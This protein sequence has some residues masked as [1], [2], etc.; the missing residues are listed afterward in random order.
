[1]DEIG[2]VTRNYYDGLGRLEVVVKNLITTTYPLTGTEPPARGSDPTTNLR[3]DY[4][5]DLAGN[6]TQ[7]VDPLGVVTRYDFDDLNRLV[8]VLENFQGSAAPDEE[9][10]VTT[11]YTYDVKGNLVQI[12]DG[13][14]HPTTRVYDD[15][16]RLR[17]EHDALNHTW[18]YAY[19]PAGNRVQV[20]D[21]LPITGTLG[22]TYDALGNRLTLRYPDEKTVRYLY[23]GLNRLVRVTD[24]DTQIT[25]YSYDAAS[26]QTV[27]ELPNGVT[28]DYMYDDLGRVL[29]MTHSTLTETL[30][31]FGYTYDAMG[32][33]VQAVESVQMPETPT[34]TPTLT[35][36]LTATPTGTSTATPTA[37]A[38]LTPTL[39]P[40][41]TST[42][43]PF[44]TVTPTLTATLT[45]TPTLTATLEATPTLSPTLTATLTSTPT[46]TP[47]HTS[48]PTVTPTPTGG[49]PTEP[50]T[51]TPSPTPTATSTHTP[52]LTPTRTSTP[53]ATP[54]DLIF[55]DS[56]ESGSF[57]AWSSYTSSGDLTVTGNAALVGNYG[58]LN[59]VNHNGTL[60]VQD[61][62]PNNESS[63]RARF[64]FDPNTIQMNSAG[65]TVFQAYDE[66]TMQPIKPVVRIE[67]G[68]V[69]TMNPLFQV[70]VAIRKDNNEWISSSAYTFSDG[71][72]AFE[73]RWKAATGTGANNGILELWLDGVLKYS[74]TAVDNDTHR[75]DLARLGVVS[76]PDV[77]TSGSHCL[78]YFESRQ[79]TYIGLVTGAVGCSGG[80]LV[81]D[82]LTPDTETP[83]TET[84]DTLLFADGFESGD[85]SAW[86]SYTNDPD[87]TVAT[88]A[89]LSG[90][91]GLAVL[92]DDYR[93]VLVR[94]D[95]PNA[96]TSYQVRFYLDPHSLW[97]NGGN[98]TI[99][100]GGMT[101]NMSVLTLDLGHQPDMS[102]YQLFVSTRLEDHDWLFSPAFTISDGPH[103]IEIGW[104]AASAP[105]IA[106][107]WLR[108]WLDG[109]LVYEHTLVANYGLV[110]DQ[111]EWGAVF[112]PL[113]GSSGTYCLDAFVSAAS[114]YLGTGS[115]LTAC[116]EANAP[117]GNTPTL[118]PTSTLTP[119]RTGT[120]T[121]T[122]P[123]PATV[124]A[125]PPTPTLTPDPSSP[126]P[127]QPDP[128][129]P[130]S[131]YLPLVGQLGQN[132]SDAGDDGTP[133]LPDS[134]APMTSTTV[135]TYTYDALSR[136][137]NANYN[138]GLSYAYAYDPVGNT[139]AYTQTLASLTTVTTYTYDATNELMT[140]HAD[141]DPITWHY[142]FD[143]N[144]SLTDI[145]PNGTTPANG[146]RRYTYSP[147]GYLLQVETHD[148]TAYQP[149]AEMAYNGLGQRLRMTAH[150]G[151]LS[152]TTQY[153]LDLP[154]H[155]RPLSATA[156]NQTTFYLYG[157]GALAEQTTQWTYSLND[158]T[159]TAR[160]LTNPAGAVTLAR[161]YTPWGEVLEQA[162]DGDFTW[163]YFGGLMDAATGLIYVGSGQYYD[164]A[165]GRFLTRFANPGATNP[166]LPQ[167]DPLGALLGPAMLL[168]L[169]QRR[170]K[171]PGKYDHL[172]IGLV[173]VLA[174]GMSLAACGDG[175]GTPGDGTPSPTLPTTPPSGGG[176]PLPPATEPPSTPTPPPGSPT[177]IPSPTCTPTLPPIPNPGYWDLGAW[178]GIG[179]LFQGLENHDERGLF[180][181]NIVASLNLVKDALGVEKT[182]NGLGLRSGGLTVMLN[183]AGRSTARPWER[184][185]FIDIKDARNFPTTIVH[186]IGHMM[187]WNAGS[188]QSASNYTDI[189]L[190]NTE[191]HKYVVIND[192]TGQRTFTQSK[193]Y[194][195]NFASGYVEAF[196]RPSEDFAE[197]FVWHVYT[198]N[199]LDAGGGYRTPSPGRRSAVVEI[200]NLLGG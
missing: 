9:T 134:R 1:M 22:Y 5:Y 56:F 199:G 118:T 175:T 169:L 27:V 151:E 181:D 83:D 97:L 2:T 11:E 189:W 168:F 108:L 188:G 196:L 102:E 91:Y 96:E 174:L 158:G 14:D 35:P 92:V 185:F 198:Q 197:V 135:I 42:L 147:A 161:R 29:T 159:R 65:H 170:R 130:V 63:Y 182:F 48:T 164:P 123:V 23:D 30:S 105:G 119:D 146:A 81:P 89:A 187:D 47:T 61:N 18:L 7:M 57:S 80:T 76:T 156:N 124:T 192:Q 150:Q 179:V 133:T 117:D 50:P 121:P 132:P 149:Q 116:G 107:G 98:H 19:D 36:T 71:P 110:L 120:A 178:Q 139:L 68:R 25:R 38:T 43:T 94:D 177:P 165:T 138:S 79:T 106:D 104:G 67:I 69:Q 113:P 128:G 127:E 85:F 87:L 44:P 15:L 54:A 41:N 115:G 157:T 17:E 32:N 45:A 40:T 58:M 52:T 75:V 77:S 131:I 72:H 74:Q 155:A 21:A 142:T 180:L 62:S 53:T 64:Y 99:F 95:T 93:P 148:G 60:Y 191:W 112:A 166:Y 152:L 167:R 129:S 137:S 109:E 190:N 171:K 172:L 145:T 101:P 125:V 82:N 176:T 186:E 143:N 24:W 66:L 173:L 3:T 111:A 154:A 49:K 6:R 84:P 183:S 46:L 122:P 90:T 100:R 16:N 162:G 34:P 51:L 4:L 103:A 12:L 160:Q 70:R 78:D 10:N 114:G 144:G 86:S 140:A 73:I 8:A 59:E 28:S 37:T 141:G 20:V 200:L 26:R 136:L 194:A 184:I 88:T 153:L 55:A 13:N 39:T 195:G 31:Q 126:D 193:E 163:G 33:R